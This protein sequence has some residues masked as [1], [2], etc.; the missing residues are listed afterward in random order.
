VPRAL[1]LAAAALLLAGPARADWPTYFRTPS[2]NIHCLAA[3]DDTGPFLACEVLERDSPSPV[4]AR[5]ADCD[6]EWGDRF[7]LGAT[8]PAALGCHGDTVASQDGLVLPYGQSLT[9]GPFTCSSSETGLECVNASGHGFHLARA[10][11]QLF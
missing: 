8:G 5:P 3:E 7:V 4:L 1:L 10:A 9:R 11:Q 6:L 2:G